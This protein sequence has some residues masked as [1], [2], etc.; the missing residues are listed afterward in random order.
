MIRYK[1]SGCGTT[2]NQI[3]HPTAH[4]LCLH[5]FTFSPCIRLSAKS[6]LGECKRAMALHE[7]SS[8]LA[9]AQSALEAAYGTCDH[10][11]VSKGQVE[12]LVGLLQLKASEGA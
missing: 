11:A 8:R 7:V 10:A 2:P 3:P 1:H 6:L 4:P 12:A 5:V 9:V